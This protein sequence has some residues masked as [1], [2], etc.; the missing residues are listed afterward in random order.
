MVPTSMENQT[1]APMSTTTSTT[2]TS[3]KDESRRP[4]PKKCFNCGL[5]GHLI[6]ACPYTKTTRQEQEAHGRPHVGN[7]TMEIT[8][9]KTRIAELRQELQKAEM[10]NAVEEAGSVL[11]IVEPAEAPRP[12]WARRCSCQ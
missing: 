5:E 2:T 9:R 12:S 7:V 10:E 11:G 3:P 1:T 6:R 4:G 8:S